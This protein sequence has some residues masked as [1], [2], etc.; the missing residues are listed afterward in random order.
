MRACLIALL[1]AISACAPLRQSNPVSHAFTPLEGD[2][3]DL[4]YGGMGSATD[5]NLSI[6]QTGNG[7]FEIATNERDSIGAFVVSREELKT[8]YQ[9]LAPYRA[10]AVPTWR[11]A[12][13]GGPACAGLYTPHLGAIVVRWVEADTYDELYVSRSCDAQRF[14]ARNDELQRI[15][16]DVARRLPG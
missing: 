4:F 1:L 15:I 16:E 9:N 3:V 7:R 14:K 2:R 12:R 6:S 11:R 10:L 13:L 8:L 5:I